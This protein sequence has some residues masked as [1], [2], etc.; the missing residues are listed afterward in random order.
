MNVKPRIPLFIAALIAAQAVPAPSAGQSTAYTGAEAL[1]LE[2]RRMG[3]TARVLMIGAHPDDENTA[4]LATLALGEGADVAYLSLTRGDGGQNLIG[5]ELKEGLGLIRTDELVAARR[6]DGAQQFFSRAIDY[7][8]SKSAEEAFR[9]WPRDSLIADAVAVIRRFR[10]DVILSVWSGT[11]ADGHGQHEATGVVAKAAFEAAADPSMYPGQVAAGLEP[12]RARWLLQSTWRPSGDPAFWLRTGE[13]DPLFGRSHYQIS[14][15]SRSQHRSQDQGSA[16]PA[17]PQRTAVVPLVGEA[18]AGLLEDVP[19]TLLHIASLHGGSEALLTKLV[20]YRTSVEQ[21]TTSFNPLRPGALVPV[22][23]TTFA[24]LE[25]ARALASGPGLE[26]VRFRIDTERAQAAEA[27]RLAAGIVLDASAADDMVVPGQTFEVTLDVWNGGES[28]VTVESLEPSLP[29]GWRVAARPEGG[30]V[31]GPGELIRRRFRVTVPARPDF[32]DPY[33]LE[34]PHDGDMYAWPADAA[35]R[36][37]PYGPPPVQ[38]SARIRVGD[39][40]LPV[41]AEAKYVSVDKAVGERRLSVL[42][43]PR[44]GVTVEPGIVV[45]P[46]SAPDADSDTPS[47][48]E[49]AVTV[50][51]ASPDGISGTVRLETPPGWSVT[52]ASSVV[53][54][55]SEGARQSVSFTVSP[56]AD[57]EPGRH[58]IS[59]VLEAD[60]EEYGRGWTRIDYPHTQPR[61]LF[62]DAAATFPVFPV[63][64]AEGL[65][66]GFIEGAGDDAAAA[67]RRLGLEVEPITPG[68]LRSGDLGRF[69][70]IVA[71]IRTYEVR[72]DVIQAN[73]RILDWV[74]A[75]GT[76]IVQYNKQEFVRGSFAPYR[77]EMADRADRVTDEES[78]V[79]VLEPEHPAMSR[80]NRIGPADFEGWVQERG[81]YFPTNWDERWTPLLEMNDPG[82]ASLLGSLLITDYGRG[83]YVYTGL[84]LFRQLPEGVPGAYRLL[85]NLVSL[86]A[87]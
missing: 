10:P 8:Y 17:G 31:V 47:S 65:R 5:P 32:S 33:F 80:P 73:A 83:K 28:A 49:I 29:A 67:L 16:Q 48:R 41:E 86:G 58:R 45:V 40:V 70:V 79:T 50:T 15:A 54:L 43:V 69:D 38:A 37:L 84:S 74:E 24:M 25:Q 4:V 46:L 9:H 20:A 81:L 44:A 34:A 87:R 13:Y 30:T 1:G 35:L 76:Y 72:P 12:H 64:V 63:A 60:D 2:L 51:A 78:P 75:G 56:P 52:P 19:T 77:L 3:T 36:G 53:S 42:V 85:A 66:V 22:L 57:I 14:M 7:G 11:P 23:S 39:V 68:I 82:E 18:P 21:A 71:G 59:A 6:I 61:L 26:K 55:E 62:E 27:L